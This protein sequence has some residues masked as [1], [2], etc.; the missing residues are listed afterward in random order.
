MTTKTDTHTHTHTPHL[1]SISRLHFFSSEYPFTAHVSCPSFLC[2]GG[3]G[4]W[5]RGHRSLIT[6]FFHR[7]PPPSSCTRQQLDQGRGRNHEALQ[8]RGQAGQILGGLEGHAKEPPS[9]MRPNKGT[10]HVSLLHMESPKPRTVP[11]TY[12][13]AQ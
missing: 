1:I 13:G 8:R 11:G 3:G 4:I 5:C 9:I 10:D 12:G 6:P 2:L 7:L